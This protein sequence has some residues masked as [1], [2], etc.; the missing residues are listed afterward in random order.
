[1]GLIGRLW[2]PVAGGSQS[3]AA[4]DDLLAG[5][6][7]AH[8]ARAWFAALDEPTR[9]GVDRLAAGEADRF[10][11]RLDE[12]PGLGNEPADRESDARAVHALLLSRD[13]LACLAFLVDGAV[14]SPHLFVELARVDELAE[15]QGSYLAAFSFADDPRLDAVSWLEPA[16]WW[17]A[18]AGG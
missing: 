5:R 15:A 6:G 10:A 14:T 9:R 2:T 8:A 1:V 17:G 7:P 18:S 16:S 3:K 11:L 13:D 12:L 4:L